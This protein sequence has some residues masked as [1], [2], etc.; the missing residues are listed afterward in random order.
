MALG[1]VLGV[2]GLRMMDLE[3]ENKKQKEEIQEL[4]EER[5]MLEWCVDKEWWFG[6]YLYSRGII[7]DEMREEYDDIHK[8]QKEYE[9]DNP[10]LPGDRRSAYERGYIG[11]YDKFH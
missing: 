4:K 1:V 11:D 9:E 10:V 5:D 2:E 3:M 7:N 8:E 6:E